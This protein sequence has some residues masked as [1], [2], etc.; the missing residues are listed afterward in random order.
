MWGVEFVRKTEVGHW[1]CLRELC[2]I[3]RREEREWV[4]RENE[5]TEEMGSQLPVVL[6]GQGDISW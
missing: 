4:V 6:E 2:N 3:F 1:F 5:F